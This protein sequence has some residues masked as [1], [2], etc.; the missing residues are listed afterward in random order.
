MF[1]SV[2]QNQNK[3]DKIHGILVACR[4]S[5]V[6]FIVRS[7]VGESQIDLGLHSVLKA[8]G[9]ACA[10]TPPNQYANGEA[11]PPKVIDANPDKKK[12]TQVTRTVKNIY[13]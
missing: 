7:L 8:L 13:W 5:E 4:H 12:I 3:V 11:F 1:P 10:Y 9:E 2:W 6:R